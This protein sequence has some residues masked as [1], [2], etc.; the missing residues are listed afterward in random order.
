MSK[1]K[2]PRQRTFSF[3]GTEVIVA[4]AILNEWDKF[5]VEEKVAFFDAARE[6]QPCCFA[7]CT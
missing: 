2:T 1:A 6:R 3:E 5:P 4:A 7:A